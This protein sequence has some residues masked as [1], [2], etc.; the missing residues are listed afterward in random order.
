MADK[1]NASAAPDTVSIRRQ[2]AELEKKNKWIYPAV[3]AVLALF[4]VGGF[5]YGLQSVLAM[6]GAFPAPVLTESRTP[7]PADKDAFV[8]YVNSVVKT[9]VAERPKFERS[10]SVDFDTDAMEL[11]VQGEGEATLRQTLLLIKNAIEEKIAS[12]A[13]GEGKEGSANKTD[14]FAPFEGL[15]SEP[16]FSASDV[17]SY[18]CGYIYYKCVNCGEESDEKRIGCEACGSEY[19]YQLLYRDDYSFT[20]ELFPSEALIGKNYSLRDTEAIA[21]A[22]N[23]GLQDVSLRDLTV[24]PEALRFYCSVGREEDQ[25]R[26]VRYESDL[27]VTATLAFSGNYA[28]LGT[29][30]VS[31]P[32]TACKSYTFTWPALTLNQ[33]VL[34]LEPKE[35]NNLLATLICDEPTNYKVDWST[36]DPSAVAVDTEGYLTAGKTAGVSAVITATFRFGEEEYSDSCVVTVKVPVESMRLNTRRLTMQVN[37]SRTLTAK[38]SPAKATVRTANW[39]TT[40]PGV[41]T[42]DENGVLTAVSPGKATVYAYSD[43]GAFKSSCE[44]TVK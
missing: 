25:L 13:F 44:V 32:A 28:A 22:L 8:S 39:H 9:A 4:F 1:K 5:I 43:D 33:H 23:D 29:V 19:E 18:K 3:I 6:E 31:L 36:S 14:F 41:V 40:D 34:S 21:A 17:A 24:Q 2:E 30:S 27:L 12:G 35:K 42:V 11:T 26:S 15:F 20:A 16:A 38:V 37:E 7:A 10:A